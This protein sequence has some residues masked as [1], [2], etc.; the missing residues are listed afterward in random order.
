ME[1][2]A[3]STS[4]PTLQPPAGGPGFS[5]AAAGIVVAVLALVIA[6]SALFLG[7]DD[8]A[9]EATIAEPAG[10]VPVSLSEFAISPASLEVPAGGSLQVT[11]DGT[12]EH[13]LHVHDTELGTAVLGAGESETLDLSSLEPGQYEVYCS[14][15]GHEDAGMAA[16][17]TI[18]E[19][20]GAADGGA[21]D[22][23]AATDPAGDASAGHGTG[24]MTEEDYRRLDAAMQDSIGAFP[25]ETEGQGAQLL[26]PEVLGDGTKQFELTAEIT[27]WEIEPGKVV[28]A[29]TYN[30]TVPAPTIKV[31]LGDRVRI[32]LHNE[33]PM[34]TDLHLHGI[35]N[36]ANDMDGVAPITQPLV[37]PGESFTYEFVADEVAVAMYHPHH[38]GQIK[39][40]N[41]MLGTILVGDLPLPTGQTVAGEAIPDDLTIA[42][43][44]PMVLN[45]SGAIGFALN[46][47]SFPATA[48]ITAKPGDWLLIHYLNE[49]NQ[50]HPMHMHRFEQIVVAKDGF[51]LDQPYAADTI[52]VAPGE[53]YSVLVKA[54]TAGTWVWHC[55]ILNH[56]E[57]ETGMFGMVTALV[58]E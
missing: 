58:V 49:G 22:A 16:T 39:L 41:G 27:P 38:H 42:Q 31:D 18:T 8:G 37:Q 1:T 19:G 53:R 54:D 12:V 15:P 4:E 9:G 45:D 52:N 23:G 17:L 13:D 10:A 21:A 48:P 28:D 34:G 11:N 55:H 56:V 35:K 33:L 7:D 2:N 25:A 36:L 46:G 30:G 51:V 47:K 57:R 43:E 14:V 26:E 50:A 6:A 5:V 3:Q 24:N 20:Q 32:V 44:L 40:P 29:W